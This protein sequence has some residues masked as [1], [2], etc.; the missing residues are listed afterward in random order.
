M[1]LAVEAGV[2]IMPMVEL[3][4]YSENPLRLAASSSSSSSLRPLGRHPH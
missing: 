1:M 3:T 4:I 2:V